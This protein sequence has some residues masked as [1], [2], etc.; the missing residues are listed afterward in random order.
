MEANA[1]AWRRC[2]SCLRKRRVRPIDRSSVLLPDMFDPVTSRSVPGGHLVVADS[3]LVRSADD[4]NLRRTPDRCRLGIA[5]AGLSRHAASNVR[6]VHLA[7]RVQPVTN[8]RTGLMTPSFQR[9][10]HVKVPQRGRL[11]DEVKDAGTAAEFGASEDPV[12]S[13]HARRSGPAIGRQ[14][15]AE[16]SQHRRD[17]RDRRRVLEKRVACQSAVRRRRD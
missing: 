6:R 11:D 7:E 12:Q 9:E 1:A 2:S 10:Q 13:A 5:H 14:T 4:P 8:V 16:I 3:P 15:I 17:E